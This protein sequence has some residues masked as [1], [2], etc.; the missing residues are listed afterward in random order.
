MLNLNLGADCKEQIVRSVI[1]RHLHKQ[2][3]S[4][5]EL[6]LCIKETFEDIY[7][8][9]QEYYEIEIG[10]FLCYAGRSYSYYLT[11][12]IANLSSYRNNDVEESI[13]KEAFKLIQGLLSAKDVSLPMLVDF[14]FVLQE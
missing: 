7:F 6:T 12:P 10:A 9:M 4:A 8:G 3:A 13:K 11:Y 1:D 2:Y 5:N 14:G